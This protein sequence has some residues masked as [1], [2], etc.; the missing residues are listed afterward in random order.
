[1]A[2]PIMMPQVGQDVETGVIVEWRVKENDRVEKGDVIALVE[3]D[4]ATFEVEAYESGTLLKI[5][6][7]VG[8]EAKVLEPIAYIGQQG[9]KIEQQ[10]EPASAEAA[11]TTVSESSEDKTQI[12]QSL[13]AGVSVSPSAKRIAL[14]HDI[15]LT[16]IKGT[17][18]QGRITK[19]DV[20]DAIAATTSGVRQPVATEDKEI[21]FSKMRKRIAERLTKSKQTI[22]HFYLFTDVDMT[23]ACRARANYNK[24]AENKITFNDMIVKAVASALTEFGALNAH[25]AEDKV[26]LRKSINIGVAVSV[27]DGLLVP[28]IPDADQKSIQEISRISRDNAEGAKKGLLKAQAIGTFTV[29]NL[30]M[31]SVNGFLPIINP[32][33]CAILGVGNIEKRAVALDDN[34]VGVREMMT[35]AIACDHR[36]VDGTYAAQ[37]LNAVKNQLEKFVL[38]TEDTE[39]TEI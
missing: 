31:Y 20:L 7:N 2:K 14:Q 38:A 23:A 27:D 28:V 5:L 36:V 25:T 29:S 24:Q 17:G 1:M 13:K 11:A 34:S 10:P 8:E 18:P 30:G 19:Q 4:K 39:N 6:Y 35:L 33:E 22:P 21:P 32:P 16:K 12:S 9:E 3:S 26:I 37:F 15:D